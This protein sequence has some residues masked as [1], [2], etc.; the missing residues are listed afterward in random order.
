M[1][2]PDKL[3]VAFCKGLPC[4]YSL[5]KDKNYNEVEYIRKDVLVKWFK[6]RK[7]KREAVAEKSD[8]DFDRGM[9]YGYQK[10]FEKIESR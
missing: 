7:E 2:A 6:E 1:K 4:H 3:Y 9:A 10:A 5:Q 8:N